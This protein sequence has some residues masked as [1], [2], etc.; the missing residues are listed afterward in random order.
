MK[1]KIVKF[2]KEVDNLFEVPCGDCEKKL[3]GETLACTPSYMPTSY[4]LGELYGKVVA[5]RK[6]PV[7]AEIV[8][9]T[10]QPTK[11]LTLGGL[12]GEVAMDFGSP[13]AIVAGSA[14]LLI[15]EVSYGKTEADSASYP[16]KAEVWVSQDGAKY[17]YG[18]LARLGKTSIDLDSTKLNWFRYVKLKDK[19]PSNY[20][21][22]GFDLNYLSCLNGA[23]TNCFVTV[24]SNLHSTDVK[25]CCVYFAW[26]EVAGA[27]GYKIAF[28]DAGSSKW[29]Y[30][31]TDSTHFKVQGLPGMDYTIKVAAFCEN[32]ESAYSEPITVRSLGEP[33]C[34][35]PTN[36]R[37]NNVT[38]NSARVLADAARNALGGYEVMYRALNTGNDEWTVLKNA[39]K[40][41]FDL[42]GLEEATIYEYQV[43]TVC[44][45]DGKL[46]SAWT[47]P[48]TF[49]TCPADIPVCDGCPTPTYISI[50]NVEKESAL[51]S[52]NKA[53]NIENYEV[54]YRT[55][56]ASRWTTQIVSADSAVLTN[57]ISGMKY[58][59]VVRTICDKY[60]R[61]EWLW[62][63]F[64]T[65]GTPGCGYPQNIQVID[66]VQDIEGIPATITTVSWSGD[67]TGVTHYEVMYRL[68]GN[69]ATR[70]YLTAFT[71][72]VELVGLLPA[73]YEFWIR[74]MCPYGTRGWNYYKWIKVGVIPCATPDSKLFTFETLDQNTVKANWVSAIGALD[75]QAMF[76]PLG[77]DTWKQLDAD[78]T[79]VTM[80][81][82]YTGTDYQFQVRSV[83]ETP[84]V[85]NFSGIRIFR[86]EGDPYCP[87]VKNIQ[88][89]SL[90]PFCMTATWEETAGGAIEYQVQYA[91]AGTNQWQ[92]R[93]VTKN[94]IT[95]TELEAGKVYDFRVRAI[96]EKTGAQVA[97]ASPFL[98]AKFTA[99]GVTDG[100]FAISNG[101][102]ESLDDSNPFVAYPNP[103]ES[104]MN[105]KLLIDRESELFVYDVMG[106]MMSQQKL[107]EGR[108]NISVATEGW[109]AGM[110][111]VKIVSKD[112]VIN[113]TAKMIKQ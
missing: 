74:A 77:S 17:V 70:K 44:T 41:V 22:D 55:V 110:Y 20:G 85:S 71:N 33:A 56:G 14:D 16:E 4:K 24:P 101:R 57:L 6:I 108:N 10:P 38:L 83:C 19:T 3:A 76:R 66:R 2:S 32:G 34:D 89:V 109:S 97:I 31:T 82:L 75:Y 45:L 12:G 36:P 21:G 1:T 42:V 73:T 93:Y 7:N 26:D 23:Y 58:E 28:R 13:I 111:V 61:S 9:V 113:R 11:F 47:E 29:H 53:A 103:F 96:C 81:K 107:S 39:S 72:Q 43:K 65:Q 49:K 112:G 27:M 80:S 37:T 54:M 8:D 15:A 95:V 84:L 102:E 100:N 98:N 40:P 5:D 67:N 106:R 64:E 46:Y 60:K 18:G 68:N 78:T 69:D 94:L 59:T 87:A 63:Y 48:K 88:F 52:W 104:E 51:V 35:M 50:K 30:A 105:F 86:T 25:P 99:L 91:V 92:T 62:G 79:T 90:L